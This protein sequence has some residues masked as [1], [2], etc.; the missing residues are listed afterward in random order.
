MQIIIVGAGSIGYGLVESL[1]RQN[2]QLIVI[3][4]DKSLIDS[5]KQYNNV[6]AIAADAVNPSL[7]SKYLPDSQILIAVTQSDEINILICQVAKYLNPA[8]KTI[9]R[10]RNQ[11]ILGDFKNKLFGAY[12]INIDKIISPELEVGNY[13]F[14]LLEIPGL[15]SQINFEDDELKIAIIKIS[16]YSP[17][18]NKNPQAINES[19][20]FKIIGLI[21]AGKYLFYDQ[22]EHIV[23]HDQLYVIY[24]DKET[25]AVIQ[26]S[27]LADKNRNVIIAGGTGIGYHILE[28]FEKHPIPHY[29][30][31]IEQNV[32]VCEELASTFPHTIIMHGALDDIQILDEAE[33]KK[34]D[35][36][37]ATTKNDNLNILLAAIAKNRGCKKTAIVINDQLNFLKIA[38][39]LGTDHIINPSELI[40][41]TLINI[42]LG[43]SMYLRTDEMI[44]EIEVIEVKATLKSKI[45]NQTIEEIDNN[46][47]VVFAAIIR[48]K[49]IIIAKNDHQIM[50]NDIV[51]ILASK[52]YQQ[53]IEYW[54]L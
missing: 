39:T 42:L 25:K 15:L 33:I 18:L 21:R 27:G 20:K 14:D 5:L 24:S 10:V 2:Y 46:Q 9:C 31:V 22:V 23:L 52:K 7:L 3:D 13:I 16:H 50:P 30:K 47:E 51:I 19:Y 36:F 48:N 32:D 35:A 54:F 53:L 40:V 4:K 43:S 37:I 29:V 17:L 6:Q 45:I 28:A 26:I 44:E 38:K 41:N 49:Q 11:S 34:A 8:V 12:K 1:A